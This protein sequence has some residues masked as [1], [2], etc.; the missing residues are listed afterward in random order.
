MCLQL[1][2]GQCFCTVM[3]RGIKAVSEAGGACGMVPV[4]S[5]YWGVSLNSMFCLHIRCTLLVCFLLF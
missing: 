1:N 2:L 5:N 3:G 4:C